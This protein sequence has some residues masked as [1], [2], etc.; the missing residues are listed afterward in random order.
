MYDEVARFRNP[1]LDIAA[2]VGDGTGYIDR[3][4]VLKRS[5]ATLEPAQYMKAKMPHR[6]GV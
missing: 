5:S 1:R 2:F 3:T 6:I 4:F